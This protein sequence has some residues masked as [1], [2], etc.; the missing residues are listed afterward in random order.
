MTD[1]LAVGLASWIIQDGNYGDFRRGDRKAF[2]LE[3]FAST[4]L[5]KVKAES[6]TLPSLE[7]GWGAIHKALGKVVHVTDDWWVIDTGILIYNGA[8]KP[9][10]D[11]RVGDRV[12]GEIN[13]GIDPFAYF[14]RLA[15]DPNAPALIYDWEIE[16]IEMQTSPFVEVQPRLRTRDPRQLGMMEIDATNAWTD[17]GGAADYVLHCRRLDGPARRTRSRNDQGREKALQ[18]RG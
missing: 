6:T 9:P 17:D 18:S 16:K 10:T 3:F 12:T 4:D 1:L 14:E 7:R 8:E 11:V 5:D 13:V 15:R 2:A